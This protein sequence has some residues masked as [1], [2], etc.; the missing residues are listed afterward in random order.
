ME[1][2]HKPRGKNKAQEL[3]TEANRKA[4][5]AKHL[6]KHPKDLK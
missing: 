1:K 2:L 5:R 4:R 3:R 6:L